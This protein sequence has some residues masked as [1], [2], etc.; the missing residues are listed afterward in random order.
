[1]FFEKEK[2][3]VHNIFTTLSKQ[4]LGGRLLWAVTDGQGSNFS[5]EFKLKTCNNLPFRICCENIVD[6][7]LFLK[8]WQD[9]KG[10]VKWAGVEEAGVSSPTNSDGL[11]F[12]KPNSKPNKILSPSTNQFTNTRTNQ[13]TKW[14]WR[15]KLTQEVGSLI[16]GS[17]QSAPQIQS[18]YKAK[19]DDILGIKENNMKMCVRLVETIP[20][21]VV[22]A[23]LQPSGSPTSVEVSC[24]SG[25]SNSWL[26][27]LCDS[28]KLILPFSYRGSL[29]ESSSTLLL[30]IMA[31]I[32]K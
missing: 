5:G 28:R 4:I 11:K 12:V 8:K 25:D 19:E 21:S 24:I 30:P 20:E 1:M 23:A 13:P 6:V 29:S 18:D 9:G 14:V 15:Q 32:E 2:F 31:G 16:H 17:T 7:A 27:Q 22:V 10:V 3:Y 26:L